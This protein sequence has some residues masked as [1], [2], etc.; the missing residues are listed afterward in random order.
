MTNGNGFWDD[1]PEI[2]TILAPMAEVTDPVFRRMVAK[3][4]KPDVLYTE[5]VSA[6]GLM[7]RGREMLLHDLQFHK[8]ERPIVAQIFDDDPD[9][10]ARATEYICTLGFDGVD[11]NMGCPDRAVMKQGAGAALI[12]EPKRAIAIIKAMKRAAGKIPVSIK[13]RLGVKHDTLD[14]WLPRLLEAEPAAIIIHGRTAKEL[15][16]VPARWERIGHAAKLA[17]G[18]GIR[19]IGNGDVASREDG[20]ARCREHG[21]G[22]FMAGRAAIGNP[23][24]FS[25][26]DNITL[27]ERLKVMCEHARLFEKLMPWKPFVHVRKHLA[28]YA[29]GVRDI[30][31]LRVELMAAQ[32]AKE[33]T[34]AA[35]HFLQQNKDI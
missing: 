5:F 3:Y 19:I 6:E 1:L 32:N 23:Y 14:E 12:D 20:Y 8:S 7:S 16:L 2:C 11:I 21:L 10:C 34:A 28:K 31:T 15:S 25:R 27:A 4:G 26:R 30:K 33:V 17:A 18:S 9:V 24:F 22:G 13:T 35:K 29:S